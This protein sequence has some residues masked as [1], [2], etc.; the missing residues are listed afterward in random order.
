MKSIMTVD[1]EYD[2]ETKE[3]RNLK[4]VLPKL[5]SFFEK[6]GIRAT[7][8]VLGSLAEKN[9]RLIKEIAKKHEIGCHGFD[10]VDFSKL[11]ENGTAVQVLKSKRVFDSLGVRVTGFRAPYFK[12]NK[13]LYD[14]LKAA[15][16]DYDSSEFGKR[17]YN[18]DGILEFQVPSFFPL[19]KCGLSFYRLLLPA[20]CCS[21][22]P[23]KR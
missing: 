5:L 14:V 16:F 9:P 22:Y 3:L 21:N 15:G 12:T 2:W 7:F 20:W 10:H 6:H 23:D 1:L 18:K 17:V 4:E 13:H 8:F 19:V 11:S